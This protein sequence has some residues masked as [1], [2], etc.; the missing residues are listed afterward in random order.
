MKLTFF[1]YE[2]IT[3]GGTQTLIL[4]MA[5]WLMEHQKSN[6]IVVCK[7]KYENDLEKEFNKKRIRVEYIKKNQSNYIIEIVK[8]FKKVECIE[9]VVFNLI[10]L[11]FLEKVQKKIKSRLDISVKKTL[12]VVHYNTLKIGLNLKI[13]IIQNFI[14]LVF[15]K[16]IKLYLKFSNIVFMDEISIN[17]AEKY[18]NFVIEK[19]IILRLPIVKKDY[20]EVLILR[21]FNNDFFRILT[22]ARAEFPFK[23]YILGLIDDFLKIYD[24]NNKI[25]LTIITNGK[26]TEIILDKIKSIPKEIQKNIIVLI[27]IPYEK[28]DAF[29]ANA[30][31]Y[32]GM[33][34]TILE[35][36][37]YALPAMTS[38]TYNFE[39]KVI[40]YFHEHPE[41][42]GSENYSKNG[43][44]FLLELI[45]CNFEKYLDISSKSYDSIMK[46]Y[47]IDLVMNKYLITQENQNEIKLP[48][49]LYYIVNIIFKLI[50]IKQ[51]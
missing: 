42:L 45:Y 15:L 32:I 7:N 26:E 3:Y 31:C 23:G 43:Y 14:K 20:D 49:Y 22:I 6:V 16:I 46:Y 18:Y 2:H 35:A 30:N 13:N 44:D 34:T 4:R 12:Y 27:N 47:D 50:S 38:S 39:N 10:D 21:R 11:V 29:F 37:S 48:L 19:K 36:A 5:N 17:E 25:N 1:L 40:G 33:G 51:M 24:S 28:L 41:S 8:S 9:F